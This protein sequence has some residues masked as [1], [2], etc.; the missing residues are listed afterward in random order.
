MTEAK[1]DVLKKRVLV[2]DDEREIRDVLYEL[3]T[4]EGFEVKTATNGVMA[5]TELLKDP[6]DLLITDLNMPQMNGLELVER[7]HREKLGIPMIMMSSLI[8]QVSKEYVRERGVSICISK[9]F[10]FQEFTD[11]VKDGLGAN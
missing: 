5:L 9:P 11:A 8:A 4:L 6:Y 1:R 10:R 3:L 7:I 2:V